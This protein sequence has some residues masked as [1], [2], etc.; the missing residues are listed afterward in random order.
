[1]DFYR[2]CLMRQPALLRFVPKQALSFLRVKIKAK[3]LTKA[4]EDF[5]VFLQAL[6]NREQVLQEFW[7]KHRRN[8]EPWY[9]AQKKEDD[10]VISASP[11]FLL[12]PVCSRLG[13]RL[14]ASRVDFATG[15]YS[16]K[17]CAGE[18]KA[19]RF[20]EA[21][22]GEK[23]HRFYSDALKDQAL[24]RHGGG[25]FSGAAGENFSLA[26]KEEIAWPIQICSAC[27]GFFR[28]FPRM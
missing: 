5:F 11:E 1:V 7:A 15:R 16:G 3:D 26:R 8:V 4:K 22:P 14:L 12:F 27:A 23:I 6:N 25:E 17:N 21:F 2:F 18:E 10:L 28:L 24:A 9:L 19:R 13:I 20:L